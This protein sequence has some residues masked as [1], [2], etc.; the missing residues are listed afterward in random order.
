MGSSRKLLKLNFT[1]DPIRDDKYLMAKLK[2]FNGINIATF[3]NN[4]IPIER[5]SY[6]CIPAIDIDSV[7]RID[8][9]RSYPHAYLEQWKYKLKKKRFVNFINDEIIDESSNSDSDINDELKL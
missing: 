4:K 7:L 2:I 1:V 5:T 3:T 8:N 9:K 6:N